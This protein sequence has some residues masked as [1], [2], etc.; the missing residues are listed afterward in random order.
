MPVLVM[1]GA[2]LLV[3]LA[4][5]L[6]LLA[7]SGMYFGRRTATRLVPVIRRSAVDCRRSAIG[8]GGRVVHSRLPQ[9]L[10]MGAVGCALALPSFAAPVRDLDR[11]WGS[12]MR[13]VIAGE[14]AARVGPLG[15]VVARPVEEPAPNQV[16]EVPVRTGNETARSVAP[17][18]QCVGSCGRNSQQ[19][20][21]K[22]K[23]QGKSKKKAKP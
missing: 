5:P 4:V 10:A 20:K 3:M 22:S 16:R 11:G 7:V 21:S 23:S 13:S 12:G 18:D 2:G 6:G 8:L 15:G 14:P 17:V 19:N 9:A 1:I